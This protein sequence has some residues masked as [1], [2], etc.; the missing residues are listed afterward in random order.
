VRFGRVGELLRQRW[1]IELAVGVD[2]VSNELGPLPHEERASSEQVAGLAFGS[3]VGVGEGEQSAAEHARE[4]GGVDLVALGLALVDVLHGQGV[5][6][7]EGDALVGAQIGEPVP[8]EH[9]LATDDEVLAIGLDGAEELGGA[10]GQVL[11][12]DGLTLVVENV[13]EHG[14]GVEID[15]TVE[16]VLAVVD[17]VQCPR[18]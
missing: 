11:R 16:S 3:R 2:D 18:R 4:L 12:E 14:P 5:A 8:G 10:G 7:S 17:H 1:Q 6:Q 9:A 15:P 13:H